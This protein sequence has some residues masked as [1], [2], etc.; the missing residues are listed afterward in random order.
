MNSWSSLIIALVAVLALALISFVGVS[1]LHLSALFG[2]W[3]PYLAGAIFL[4]GVVYRI[5]RWAMVPV[6]FRI[7]TTSGQGYSLPWI[8]SAYFDCPH[9]RVGLIGRMALEVLL[10]RSLFRNT[11]AQLRGGPNVAYG[12][13]Q[14]LWLF[15]ILFHYS[16]LVILLRHLR[17]FIEPVPMFV[18]ML[19]SVDGF[20]DILFPALFLTDLAL[21]GAATYLFLR[22]VVLPQ[23]RYISLPADYFPLFLILA[24]ATTGVLMRV[25]WKVNLLSVKELVMGMST[26]HPAFPQDIG[27]IFYIHLFLVC[28][29]IA[30]L[31]F[32]KIMHAGGV[33]LSPTRNMRN[34]NRMERWVNPW[35]YPVK[36]HSYAEYEDDFREKMKEAGIPVEK[37]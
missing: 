15:G 13:N 9:T 12:S 36:L 1:S 29:L 6:P 30:Y 24:I 32:S 7:P 21:L 16:F 22:R 5:V 10:F 28:V 17:F 27:A 25:V 37:E 26:F 3:I 31:P 8:K 34:V 23:M 35:D 19:T 18:Q 11:K 4:I 33:F 20:F 2:V 14:W